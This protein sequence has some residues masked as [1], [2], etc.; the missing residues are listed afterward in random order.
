VADT[1]VDPA[2]LEALGLYD[3][4]DENAAGRLERAG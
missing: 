4:N 3:P 2:E 1:S